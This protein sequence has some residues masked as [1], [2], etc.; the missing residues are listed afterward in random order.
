MGE[1]SRKRENISQATGFCAEG[2]NEVGTGGRVKVEK[3]V[4]WRLEGEG[5][6]RLEEERRE[7]ADA[8]EGSSSVFSAPP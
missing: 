1:N 3:M 2:Q 8:K 6:M 4:R 5:G 7:E